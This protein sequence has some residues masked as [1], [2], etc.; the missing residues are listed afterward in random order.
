MNALNPDFFAIRQGIV[1]VMECEGYD[2]KNCGMNTIER[3]WVELLSAYPAIFRQIK[4]FHTGVFAN[5]TASLMKR[6]LPESI[7]SKFQLGCRFEGR[8]DTF[9]LVP[10][11]ES[12]N[13]RIVERVQIC[14]RRRLENDSNFS[15]SSS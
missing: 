7:H 14:L 5:L 6:F 1:F 12:A 11:L 2:W 3:V 13:D 10:S 15:L 4:Y 8:L 9:Y